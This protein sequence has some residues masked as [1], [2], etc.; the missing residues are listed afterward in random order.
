M[1][2]YSKLK[3]DAEKAFATLTNEEL[4]ALEKAWHQARAAKDSPIACIH[5]CATLSE[6]IARREKDHP[7]YN[8]W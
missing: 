5:H 6:I 2:N 8:G 1:T 7:H 3:A 4:E